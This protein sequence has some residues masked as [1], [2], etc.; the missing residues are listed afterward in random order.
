MPCTRHG[1]RKYELRKLIRELYRKGATNRLPL[2]IDRAPEPGRPISYLPWRRADHLRR[3]LL[4]DRSPDIVCLSLDHPRILRNSWT[5]APAERKQ[6]ANF[7]VSGGN[8]SL[9]HNS[10]RDDN[11]GRDTTMTD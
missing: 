8:S 1:G 5:Q 10:S 9:V 4:A 3:T 11:T 6:A 2:G 7:N